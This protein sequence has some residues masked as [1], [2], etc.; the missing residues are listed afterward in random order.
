M[1]TDQKVGGS[2]PLAHA[3][4]KK[5]DAIASLFF[6]SSERVARTHAMHGFGLR[7]APV[8][9][10]PTSTGRR[11]PSSARMS[12][13]NGVRSLAINKRE[14]MVKLQVGARRDVL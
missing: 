11:G 4:T 8:G 5:R 6:R 10:K 9:P 2:N 13:S 7:F 12:T 14:Y 1:A 3:R